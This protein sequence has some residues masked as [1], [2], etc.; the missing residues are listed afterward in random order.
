MSALYAVDSSVQITQSRIDLLIEKAGAAPAVWFRYLGTDLGCTPGE[1]AIAKANNIPV[2]FICRRSSRVHLGFGDG[3]NDAAEDHAVLTRIIANDLDAVYF[4]FVFLD[5]E[6]DCV[7][8][9]MTAEYYRGFASIWGGAGSFR[10]AV[11][12]P[13]FQAWPTSWKALASAINSGAPCHGAWV[14]RYQYQAQKDVNQGLS[15]YFEK[16]WDGTIVPKTNL[17]LPPT[18]LHQYIGN[19]L[20]MQF[21]FSMFNPDFRVPFPNQP[22]G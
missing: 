10:P 16:P 7:A 5:V 6:A 20:K 4:P 14:A 18:V 8:V 2:G 1:I 9:P 12:M 21:D 11:Y 15:S 22:I 19:A 17:R 13:C 3:R